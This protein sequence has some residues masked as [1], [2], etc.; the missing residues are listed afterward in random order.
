VRGNDLEE[1][2]LGEINRV[3]NNPRIE[4]QELERHVDQKVDQDVISRLEEELINLTKREKRL[5]RLYTLGTVDE[6]A[7]RKESED[8]SLERGLLQQELNSVQRSESIVGR[9]IDQQL[10]DRACTAVAQWLE[11]ADEGDRMLTL[12]ALQITVKATRKSAVVSGILPLDVPEFIM[13]EQTCPCSF[14]GE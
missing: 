6:E 4:L 14:N 7:I 8:I 13:K 10:M 9:N 11:Q 2:V 12:E 1:A 3:L 5:V